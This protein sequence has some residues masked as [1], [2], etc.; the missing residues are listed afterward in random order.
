MK[1]RLTPAAKLSLQENYSS[2]CAL[3]TN[4]KKQLLPKKGPAAIQKKLNCMRQNEMTISE[5]GKEITELFVD[6][7]IS[8]ADGS[9]ESYNVLKPINERQAIKQFSDGL[10]NRRL[11][12][13]AARNFTSLKDAIQSAKDE[14]TSSTG[15]PSTSGEIMGMNKK[16]FYNSRNFHSNPRYFRGGAGRHMSFNRGGPREREN[17]PRVWRPPTSR[18]RGQGR[19]GQNIRGTFSRSYRGNRGN[20]M[21]VMNENSASEAEPRLDQFFRE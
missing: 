6:L 21:N 17:P 10:R 8:Q 15:N 18:G 5:F 11:S 2:E 1:S 16:I 12:T 14:E 4:M 7:T 20:T 9:T 3:I 13:I 19:R